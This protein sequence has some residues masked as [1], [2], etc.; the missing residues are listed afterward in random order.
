MRPY[1]KPDMERPIEEIRAEVKHDYETLARALSFPENI[2]FE[3]AVAAAK[4]GMTSPTKYP[5]K[6]FQGVFTDYVARH[7]GN[8]E[9]F[10]D[11]FEIVTGV[12][13]H[14]PHDDLGMSPV[15]MMRKDVAEGQAPIDYDALREK[16]TSEHGDERMFKAVDQRLDFLSDIARSHL[17][18]YMPSIGG[19]KKN[20][21][22]IVSILADPKRDPQDAL[23]YLLIDMSRARQA[24]KMRMRVTFGD[25]QPVVRVI[26]MCEN[27]VASTM[28]NG[29][30]NSRMFQAIAEQCSEYVAKTIKESRRAGRSA[31]SITITE[32][33]KVLDTLLDIHSAISETAQR[34]RIMEG[35]EEAAHHILDWLVLTDIHEILGCNSKERAVHILAV[36]RLIATT[37]D[38]KYSFTTLAPKLQ[39]KSGYMDNASYE[40]E[41]SRLAELVLTNCGDPLQMM[42]IPGQEP[43]DCMERLAKL[44][45]SLKLRSPISLDDLSPPSPFI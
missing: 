16:L 25:I 15:E 9:V 17:E 11:A 14:F 6:E 42:P 45:P 30:K 1:T 36:A 33:V 43:D 20:A 13:N 38:P 31:G 19:T 7:S 27:H 26:T 8:E 32:P 29:H 24:K 41:I 34:L 35:L 10:T 18:H 3:A 2:K 40:R 28:E 12:W 44:A 23:K 39:T 4:I 21:T 22:H 37:G 5:F